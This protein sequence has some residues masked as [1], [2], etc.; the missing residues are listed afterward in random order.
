MEWA[1]GLIDSVLGKKEQQVLQNQQGMAMGQ[2]F[3]A[4][5]NNAM[6]E[7]LIFNQN[8]I[9]MQQHAA[10]ARDQAADRAKKSDRKDPYARSMKWQNYLGGRMWI[11][12][13]SYRHCGKI[14]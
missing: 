12:W 5:G 6:L 4:F 10:V 9:L 13:R 14:F 2:P 1:N 11:G 3:Q 8:Q 7:R